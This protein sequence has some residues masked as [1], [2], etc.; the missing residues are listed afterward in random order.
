[1][2][3]AL[4]GKKADGSAL[5]AV[6][7]NLQPRPVPREHVDEIRVEERATVDGCALV[8]PDPGRAFLHG[9]FALGCASALHG[10]SDSPQTSCHIETETGS[11]DCMARGATIDP[12]LPD[13]GGCSP[14]PGVETPG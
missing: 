10:E 7:G 14:V 2:G 1:M 6:H 8:Q 13:G 9:E 4:K 3:S 11:A 5:F 12:S